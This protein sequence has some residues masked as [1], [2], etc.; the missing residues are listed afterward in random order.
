[1]QLIVIAAGDTGRGDEGVAHRVLELLGAEPNVFVHDVSQLDKALAEEIAPADEVLFIDS[2]RE[3]GDPWVEPAC[4]AAEA[5]EIVDLARSRYCFRGHAYVCHVP[6]LEFSEGSRL[7]AYAE[8]RARKAADLVRRFLAI[9]P[10]PA[11]I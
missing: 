3:L 11:P 7:T 5:A 10:E 4:G 6:G 8:A 2:S 1:M 9:A